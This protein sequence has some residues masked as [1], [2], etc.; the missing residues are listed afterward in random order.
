MLDLIGDIGFEAKRI[1]G[2]KLWAFQHH[3]PEKE[4]LGSM[5]DIKIVFSDHLKEN[6][7]IDECHSYL[8]SLSMVM[9]HFL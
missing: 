2:G 1:G 8:F 9:F 3:G 5:R 6:S 4:Q 7:R